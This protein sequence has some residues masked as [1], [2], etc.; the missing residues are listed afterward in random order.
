MSDDTVSKFEIFQESLK[1]IE[2]LRAIPIEFIR[3]YLKTEGN[4]ATG[5]KP[6]S[7]TAQTTKED[8]WVTIENGGKSYKVPKY[9]G[10][11]KNDQIKFVRDGRSFNAKWFNKKKLVTDTN[12]EEVFSQLEKE[13]FLKEVKSS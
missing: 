12:D 7:A 4:V 2:Q 9:Y 13:G 8:L 10:R 6:S 1:Y 5:A 3:Y 11:D